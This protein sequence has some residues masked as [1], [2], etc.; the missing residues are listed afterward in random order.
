M[1]FTDQPDPFHT[2]NEAGVTANQELAIEE[3]AR[4]ARQM[5]PP[6]VNPYDGWGAGNK[7][8]DLSVEERSE[9]LAETACANEYNVAW[10]T[11]VLERGPRATRATRDVARSEVAASVWS[12]C[13]SWRQAT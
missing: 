3:I 13:K 5:A 9:L 11:V 7:Q 4:H 12:I 6:P 2:I 8:T 1:S 10:R